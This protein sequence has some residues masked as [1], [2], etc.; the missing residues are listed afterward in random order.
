MC[1]FSIITTTALVHVVGI[2]WSTLTSWF[3]IL[4]D[5]LWASQV[6]LGRTCLQYRRYKRHGLDPWIRKIPWRGAWQPI[7]VFMLGESHGQ[8]SLAGYSPWVAK[9]QTRLKQ[10][11][12][13]SYTYI[14]Q[15]WKGSQFWHMLQY[16]W[17]PYMQWNTPV[18][19]RHYT[20]WFLLYEPSII[21]FMNVKADQLCPTL[22]SKPDYWSR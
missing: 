17:G 8:R 12:T 7:L 22:F 2:S 4:D 13:H 3:N 21:K 6:A 9:S 5:A 19:K 11:H 10:R 20:T 14:I 15:P 16:E 18:I 1:T